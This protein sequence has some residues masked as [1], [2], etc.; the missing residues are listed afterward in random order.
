MTETFAHVHPDGKR[1][2]GMGCKDIAYGDCY[3]KM[4]CV[5]GIY[6]GTLDFKFSSTIVYSK[7]GA[8]WSS[9]RLVP[10]SA[11]HYICS[12]IMVITPLVL[13]SSLLR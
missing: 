12:G 8:L 3:F 13:R 10:V 11:L 6:V 1:N 4:C 5:I 9:G 2:Y 7:E